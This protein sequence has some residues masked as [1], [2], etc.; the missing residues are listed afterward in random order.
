MTRRFGETGWRRFHTEPSTEDKPVA[1]QKKLDDS[2]KAA[3]GELPA[4][5][6]PKPKPA[7]MTPPKKPGL[8]NVARAAAPAAHKPA[9]VKAV[10]VADAFDHDTAM[11]FAF[12]GAGQGGGKIAQSFWDLGYRRVAAFNTTDSDFSGLDA[13]IPKLSLDIGGAAK[14]MKLARNAMKGRDEEVWDLFTRA[15]G[16]KLDCAIVCVG[17]GGGSGSGGGLPLVQL[18][19]KYMESKGLPPRVGA[20]VSLPSVDEGQQVARNA[21]TAFKELVDAGVS[22]LIVIDNDAVDALYSPP[23]SQLLPKSN[24]LVS[25]HLHLFNQLAAAKSPHITFDRAEFAQLLD[26]GIVVMGSA[27][28]TVEEITSPADVSA[29]IK[30]QLVNSVLAKVDLRT[31]RKA[32]C[33]FVASNDV[34]DSFGKEYF[35]AGFTMLNRIVGSAHPEGTDVVVHRGLYPEGPGG[36]QCYTMV[37]ELDAP[38]AKLSALAKEAGLPGPAAGSVARHLRVD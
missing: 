10:E 12:V 32:A 7:A 23:M 33:V 13:E 29:A 18:A 4:Q 38:T 27:D 19:R 11:H 30:E 31:G 16:S 6:A 2:I 26:G 17:L 9:A 36:L 3:G 35:A 24:E 8:P 34:L 20:V 21:V 14:D 15:W 22:P 5:P 25:Q 28:L 37:S 1:D